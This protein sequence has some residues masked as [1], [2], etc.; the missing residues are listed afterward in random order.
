MPRKGLVE[1]MAPIRAVFSRDEDGY[2]SVVA[3]VNPKTIAVSDGQTLPKARRRIR[4]ALALLLEVEEGSL[5][6][7]DEIDLP[8]A[9]AS[10]KA[11]ATAREAA[12][13]AEEKLAAAQRKAAQAL[14]EAQLSRRDAGEVLGV[15][16]MRVQQ[17]LEG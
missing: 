6:I 11:L 17:L 16:G 1:V 3:K 9:K 13:K 12:R 7:V 15:T 5:D 8:S 14:T 4:E 10:L 2:W